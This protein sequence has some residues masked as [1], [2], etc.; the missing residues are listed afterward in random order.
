MT[1]VPLS[2]PIASAAKPAA[3]V[4]RASARLTGGTLDGKQDAQPSTTVAMHRLSDCVSL[5]CGA[6]RRSQEA[7]GIFRQAQLEWSRG[8]IADVPDLRLIG[9]RVPHYG[10]SRQKCHC[11]SITVMV[12]MKIRKS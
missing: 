3:C 2:W 1:V 11:V 5:A 9:T 10:S 7:Q 12:S 6:A 4:I 8:N